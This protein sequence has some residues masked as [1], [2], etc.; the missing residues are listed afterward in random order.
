M[1][2]SESIVVER[3]ESVRR[4]VLR[5]RG[6]TKSF[7]QAPNRLEVLHG[8]DLDIHAGQV[9][10]VMGPSGSGKTTLLTIMG[11]LLRP[12]SGSI[13]IDGRNV[14]DCTEGQLPAVRR[15]EITFIFQAFN[16]LSALTAAENVQIG[17]ELQGSSGKDAESM[18]LELLSRVGLGHRLHHRP[19]ELSCGERQRV[20]VA[21]SLASPAKLVLADEPTSNLDAK[22]SSQIVQLLQQLAYEDGR[23]VVVVTH[24][25]RLTPLADRVIRIENGRLEN[26]TGEKAA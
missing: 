23:A 4:A 2:Q 3:T 12:C 25:P 16:L 22:S 8:I 21:R 26:E 20:A 1:N 19:D 15:R 18:T 10:L 14:T 6:V 24:D 5:I 13:E 9:T 11:L 7:G 17:L